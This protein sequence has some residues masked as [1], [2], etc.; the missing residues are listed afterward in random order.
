MKQSMNK[1]LN[2]R[3]IISKLKFEFFLLIANVILNILIIGTLIF[4]AI[5]F[6]PQFKLTESNI[7]NINNLVIFSAL[8]IVFKIQ[9]KI[10]NKHSKSLL[11]KSRKI[12]NEIKAEKGS[13]N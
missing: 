7:I 13:E 11:A 3:S 6:N 5:K 10:L 12:L 1:H 4:L 9:I 8:I 2:N